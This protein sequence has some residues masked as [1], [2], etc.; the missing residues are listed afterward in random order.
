MGGASPATEGRARYRVLVK[1]LSLPFSPPFS[2]CN[3]FFLGRTF[4]VLLSQ[5]Y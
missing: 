5:V 3:S 4:N 1:I 2:V